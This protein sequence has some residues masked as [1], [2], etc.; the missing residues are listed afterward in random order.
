MKRY[1]STKRLSKAL[2]AEAFVFLSGLVSTDKTPDV[3]LQT[4]NVLAQIDELL[5][6]AGCGKQD[7]AFAQIWLEDISAFD[8]MNGAWEDWLEGNP[9]PARATVG[10]KLAGKGNLVEIAARAYV[11]GN[12]GG[13]GL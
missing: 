11:R 8:E 1:Q 12:Q 2:V 5:S 3:A 6:L 9:P 4:K 10:A 13:V 7:L